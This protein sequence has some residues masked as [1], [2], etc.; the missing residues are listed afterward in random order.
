MLSQTLDTMMDI[1]YCPRVVCQY[2]VTYDPSEAVAS[3]PNC[4]YSFCVLCKRVYHGVEP[5][6]LK[7]GECYVEIYLK[8]CVVRFSWNTN[9]YLNIFLLNAF[10]S[11]DRLAVIEKYQNGTDEY[12][13]EINKRYG[14]K[15]IKRLLEDHASEETINNSTKPCPKCG[16]QIEVAY[17]NLFPNIYI[18]QNTYIYN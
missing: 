6:K 14:E 17:I 3:C 10:F 4:L 7:Q 12:R 11:E 2:P 18:W 15:Y 16:V 9:I 5:C 1:I 8:M 13:Q